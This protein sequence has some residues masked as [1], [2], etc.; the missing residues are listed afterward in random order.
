MKVM[1]D[2]NNGGDPAHAASRT[3]P[4]I[5][6]EA[7]DGATTQT[8]Q[9]EVDVWLSYARTRSPYWKWGLRRDDR[10][11]ATGHAETRERATANAISA[12][13]ETYG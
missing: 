7:Q 8:L 3:P 4:P 2:I 10:L 9:Y 1:I 11:V 5:A 13:G 6:T 12:C